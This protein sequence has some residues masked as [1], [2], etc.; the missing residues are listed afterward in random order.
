MFFT[1]GLFLFLFFCFFVFVLTERLVVLEC[2]GQFACIWYFEEV[3]FS[4]L[5]GCSCVEIMSLSVVLCF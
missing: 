3:N 2:L 1:F 4:F 5:Y